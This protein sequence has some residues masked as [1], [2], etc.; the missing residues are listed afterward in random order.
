MFI[1]SYESWLSQTEISRTIRSRRL[2]KVDNALKQYHKTKSEADKDKIKLALHHWKME[3]GYDAAAGKPAWMTHPRN[4]KHAVERLDMQLY[5]QPSELVT[6]VLADLAELPFFGMEAWVADYRARQ[7]LKEARRD[8]LVELFKDKRVEF[9]RSKLTWGMFSVKRHMEGVRSQAHQFAGTAE[10]AAAAPVIAEVQQAAAPAMAQAQQI[11]EGLIDGILGPFPL[12]VAREVMKLVTEL[13][14]QFAVEIAQSIVPYLSLG[15]SFGL[16]VKNSWQTIHREYQWVMSRKHMGAFSGDNAEA[17]ALSVQRMIERVRNHHL[18]LA[19]IYG[20][21]A[22]AKSV[23]VLVDAA[24]HG[25]PAGSAL[26]G[27]AAGLMKAIA[28]T[29]LQIFLLARDIYEMYKANQL[30]DD[31][32][33][34]RLTTELFDVC[35]LLGCYFVACSN[36]S[37]LVNFIVEDIGEPGWQFDV[38]TMVKNHIEPMIAYARDAISI[39]RL[40]VPGL[41]GMNG[42]VDPTVSGRYGISNPTARLKKKLMTKIAYMVPFIDDSQALAERMGAPHQ[43]Q[44]TVPA[45]RIRGFGNPRN[46]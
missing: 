30:L 4:G 21:D 43:P 14:P 29:S 44:T 18:E 5:K 26:I 39:S 16:T 33:K 3:L 45:G 42:T 35:P 13:V 46:P 23:A 1:M 22:S 7:A 2:R 10:A 38:E 11:A 31:Y 12:E 37:D 36:T 40:E 28:K 41:A 15:V 32:K 25:A 19:A 17:A 27:S 34:V 24:C 20:A 9:P 6:P 8:A